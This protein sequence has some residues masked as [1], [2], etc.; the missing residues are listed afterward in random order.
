MYYALLGLALGLAVRT[1][2]PGLIVLLVVIV[3]FVRSTL[4]KRDQDL[5]P[6]NDLEKWIFGSYANWALYNCEYVSGNS[7]MP[8]YESTPILLGGR[9]GPY[10]SP[11]Q[12][13]YFLNML[14]SPWDIHSKRELLETVEYMSV[15]PGIRKCLTQSDRAWELCRCTQLLAIAFRLGWISRREMVRRSCQV[16]KI[17]QRTFSGWQ[18]MSES[19]LARCLQW[20]EDP[21]PGADQ[22]RAAHK[23]LWLRPDSPYNLPWDF[24]LG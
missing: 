15:G 13:Q 16:G 11:E 9:R 1:G 12:R 23:A 7:L 5:T 2:L 4:R 24:P 10:N 22:R 8:N 20:M 17:I 19:F 3:L 21:S 14:D 18:E 6:Q